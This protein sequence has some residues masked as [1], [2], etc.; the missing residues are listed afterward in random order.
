VETLSVDKHLTIL[1]FYTKECVPC[2]NINLFWN[3]LIGEISY[4]N[5]ESVDSEEQ[6]EL[7]TKFRVRSVPTFVALDID[8]NVMGVLTNSQTK[9]SLTKWVEGF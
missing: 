4:A 6:P 7:A 5:F 1:K 9:A 2:K 8:G 3:D